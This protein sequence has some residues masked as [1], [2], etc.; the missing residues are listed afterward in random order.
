M[1][2]IVIRQFAVGIIGL[3]EGEPFCRGFLNVVPVMAIKG[4]DIHGLFHR[5]D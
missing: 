1:V 2:R 5:F 4:K 3:E